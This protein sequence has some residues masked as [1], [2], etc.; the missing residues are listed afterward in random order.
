MRLERRGVS[1]SGE[2]MEW[3]IGFYGRQEKFYCWQKGAVK[4]F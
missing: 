3:Q 4:V 1:G 2:N